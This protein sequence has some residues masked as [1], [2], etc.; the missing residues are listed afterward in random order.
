MA[1]SVPQIPKHVPVV[2]GV[3]G[4]RMTPKTKHAGRK[5]RC[6]DCETLCP[7]PTVEQIQQRLEEERLSASA[8]PEQHEPYELRE[9]EETIEPSTRV[10]SKLAEI[11]Q[12]DEEII[13]PDSLFTSNVFQFPWNSTDT[14][15]R[16]C[17]SSV[18]L[19]ITGLMGWLALAML[20][21]LGFAG[22]IFVGFLILGVAVVGL[23]AA[24][25]VSAC[26]FAIL[27]ETAAGVNEIKVWPEA[28]WRDGL[29]DFVLIAWL[30]ASSGFFCYAFAF[31]CRPVVGSLTP[32]IAVTHTLIFPVA[33]ISAMDSD[34]PWFPW[35]PMTMQSL[36]KLP[37][38]WFSFYVLTGTAV[39]ISIGG[40][41][42]LASVW[43]FGTA[44]FLGPV[45][46]SA[47]FIYCRLVGRMAWKIGD[48][49]TKELEAKRDP[50]AS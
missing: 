33:L 12:D 42:A 25:Y 34:S 4:T 46:A 37:G 45:L 2:C 43:P 7:I 19:T 35:S 13:P 1:D 14:L 50:D 41:V 32:V 39:G 11:R 20:A 17:F 36:K 10:F 47:A 27:Q 23:I 40:L 44:L 49:A 30:H 31:L 18:G 38:V 9:R 6:P 28:A 5:V 24:G 29:F 8:E 3:C 21:E 22:A 16:W 26:C 48:E 15:L